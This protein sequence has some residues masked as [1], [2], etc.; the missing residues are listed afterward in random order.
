MIQSR[1]PLVSMLVL[2]LLASLAAG[3]AL[4]QQT[5]AYLD[6]TTA[7]SE[8]LAFAP[9]PANAQPIPV[10]DST[11]Q[12][13]VVASPYE[14]APVVYSEDL[15]PGVFLTGPGYRIDEGARV[16][17]YYG[18][19]I[20]RSDVGELKAE[21]AEVLKLRVRE[22]EAVR[23]LDEI[24]S[25]EVFGSAVVRGVKR[26]IEAV[27]QVLTEPVDTLT[28]IPK[29]VGRFIARTARNV[30]D[31]AY[32]IGDGTRDAMA[33][34]DDPNAPRK[35]RR[36]KSERAQRAAES[37]ALRYLGY[38]KVRRQIARQVGAD[39]YSTN[40]LIIERL[41]KLAWASWTGGKI[42]GLGMGAVGGVASDVLSYSKDAYELVWEMPPED[43]KRRN[44]IVLNEIGFEGKPA[45]DLIRNRA[46]TLT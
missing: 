29:G 36:T 31:I 46:F 11:P 44:L 14:T 38:T 6:A 34:D 17:D 16:R 12:P 10:V 39:P 22:L 32:N 45:R 5:A 41:D 9:V 8:D 15:L 24:G 1:L 3:P 20:L 30:R 2:A 28:G 13:E 23:R 35:S 33:D 21:G 43:L 18:E 37:G 40:P 25:A 19:F 4:S 26:P 42:A 27:R 7:Q